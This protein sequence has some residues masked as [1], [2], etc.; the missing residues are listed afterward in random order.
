M[1]PVYLRTM[2]S[3]KEKMQSGELFNPLDKELTAERTRVRLLLKKFNDLP[4]DQPK[5][6]SKLMKELMPGARSFWI[7]R[8]F[9]CDYGY[10]IIVGERVFFNY[11]CVVLDVGKV[12]IGN[13]TLFG[14]AVQ[15]Y[16]VTHPMDFK[17]RAAGLEKAIPVTIGED[18]WIGGGAIICAGVT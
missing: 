8:P 14:P 9:Y 12:T 11:N 18:V 13:R 1:F 15:I 10:N 17:E 2:K 5:A 4:E 6:I 7:Q 16:T 3:E